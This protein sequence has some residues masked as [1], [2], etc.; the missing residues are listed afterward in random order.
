VFDAPTDGETG[1]TY[2]CSSGNQ[3]GP[4]KINFGFGST[5]TTLTGVVYAPY[6][7]LFLQDNGGKNK[8]ATSMNTDLISGNICLQ[9]SQ[10]TVN[11]LT[12]SYSPVTRAG[13]VY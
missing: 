7:Q 2:N 4:G 9:S 13:L 11:G 12:S 10:A 3:T 5:V 1:G 8:G 6:A